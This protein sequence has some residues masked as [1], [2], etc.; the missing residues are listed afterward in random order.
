MHYYLKLIEYKYKDLVR[1]SQVYD[2]RPAKD[3]SSL[4]YKDY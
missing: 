2:I 3:K 1:I 4:L